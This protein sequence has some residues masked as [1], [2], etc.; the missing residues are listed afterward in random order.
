MASEL[1]P[2]IDILDR[3]PASSPLYTHAAELLD[4]RLCPSFAPPRHRRDR[5]RPFLTI[6]MAVYD[7]YDGAYFSAQAIR[8]YHPEIAAE[9]EIL[10]LDTHPGGPCSE[11]L[12]KLGTQVPG[13]RYV[14]AGSWRGTAARDLLFREADSAFV[15]AMDAHVLFA[16]GSLARLVEFLKTQADARDLW[17]GPL[18]DDNLA[19]V[20]THFRPEWSGG[21]YGVW[22][23]DERGADP[24]APPFEIPMQGLGA[25]VCRRE[26]W[27]GFNPRLG[28]FGGEEG[29]LHEKVR[30]AGG[31]VWCLPFLRW[32]HRFNRPMGTRYRACWRDRIRNYL[33]E[34]D[35]LGLDPAPVLAH[36]ERLLGAGAAPLAESAQEEIAGPLYAF[37]AVY[38]AGPGR[39]AAWECDPETSPRIR[40]LR[41]PAAPEWPGIGRVLTHRSILEDARRQSLGSVLIL[42][43]GVAPGPELSGAVAALRGCEWQCALLP[44]AL[45]CRRIAFDGIL[46]EIP[47]TPSDA[48]LWLRHGN[49][50]EALYRRAFT[51]Q[52]P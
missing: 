13:C 41:G 52:A 37:D 5:R 45:A 42:E 28:G 38:E 47:A 14:A 12:G 16:P 51:A 40:R 19:S 3:L 36:F 22:S 25:F 15:L 43:D 44:G 34:Y 48:A 24:A 18:L 39:D 50:L 23:A 2:F 21:M 11:A 35:E 32:V 26:A 9:T 10:V 8:L 20:S 30:R 17:Q 27:P 31:K 4:G 46:A 33:I 6:G 1:S 49:R 29:Y 7:D